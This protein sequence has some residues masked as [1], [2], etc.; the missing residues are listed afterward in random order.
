M[1]GVDQGFYI[2]ARLRAMQ[3]V[4]HVHSALED[5][6]TNDR[7]LRVAYK[8][9]FNARGRLAL[10]IQSH[11]ILRDKKVQWIKTYQNNAAM[12]QIALQ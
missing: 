7:P 5:V 11:G 1:H 4:L 6:F 9:N 8:E 10:I 12:L 2:F 3:A